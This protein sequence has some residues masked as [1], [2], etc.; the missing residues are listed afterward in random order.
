MKI[1]FATFLTLFDV[2]KSKITIEKSKK[3]SKIMNFGE[4]KN[5]EK[6][7]LCPLSM[8]PGRIFSRIMLR[9]SADSLRGRF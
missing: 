9:F 3:I 7:A 1:K 4:T 8:A 6:V 5:V 2:F